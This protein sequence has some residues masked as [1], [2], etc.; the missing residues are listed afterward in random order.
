MSMICWVLG[1]SAAQIGALRATP[2][3]ASD[4]AGVKQNEID[5]R[6]AAVA[7]RLTPEQRAQFETRY[8]ASLAQIPGIEELDART[9]EA[10]ARLE[11]IGPFER[12]LS[13]DKSWHILHY[14]FT[15]TIIPSG[16]PA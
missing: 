3:L 5:A 15:G 4:L 10:S 13:L 9:A 8:R 11:P 14:V 12:A 1:L 6:I 7:S 2:S 16:S